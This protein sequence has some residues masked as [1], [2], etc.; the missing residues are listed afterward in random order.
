MNDKHGAVMNKPD[1]LQYGLSL[2]A[3]AGLR[4]RCLA[5]LTLALL[6]GS[7]QLQAV[8]YF[9]SAGGDDSASGTSEST[10]WRTVDRANQVWLNPSDSLSF[11]GGDTFSGS[12]GTRGTGAAGRPIVYKS[13]G[14]GRAIINAGNN[15]GFRINDSYCS[16]SNLNFIGSGRNTG[17]LGVGIDIRGPHV[18][19]DN[20]GVTG[21][22]HQGV[23]VQSSNVR[24]SNTDSSG[25][26]ESGISAWHDTS[27]GTYLTDLYIGHCTTNYNPGDPTSSKWTGSGIVIAG[28]DGAT[29]E[30]CEAGHNCGAMPLATSG[31]YAIWCFTCKHVLI[32][33]CIAHDTMTNGEDGGGIDLDGGTSDSIVQYCLT[34]G[35]QGS[36][37]GMYE[38][39]TTPWARNTIRYCIS[40]NDGVKKHATALNLAMWDNVPVNFTKA[41]VYNNMFYK[42]RD[43]TDGASPGLIAFSDPGSIPSG[44]VFCNNILVS[45]ND[46]LRVVGGG[47]ISYDNIRVLGNCYYKIGGGFDQD[48]QHSLDA[49]SLAFG[50][51]RLNGSMVGL[52]ADPL[53]AAMSTPLTITNPD[54]LTNMSAFKLLAGSPCI[55][56]GIDLQQVLGINPGARD[57]F[58]DTGL[59]HNGIY[60][61][62]AH[63]ADATVSFPTITSISPNNA[64]T[65]GGTTVTITGT[66]LTGS[67]AVTFGGRAATSVTVQSDTALTCVVPS[68]GAGVVDVVVNAAGGTITAANGFTYVR[69]TPTVSWSQPAAIVYGTLLGT[70]QLNA[71][72]GVAGTFTYAPA[73]GT[74]LHAGVGQTLSVTF[75]PA[76]PN[77]YNGTA[78]SISLTVI[79]KVLT[80]TAVDATRA[81][82]AANP[83]FTVSYGGFV[84]SDGAGTLTS[85][86]TASCSAT[87]ASP[88]G[89]YP[90]S[91]SGGA[92]ADYSFSYVAG[93]LTITDLTA[94]TIT[95]I[96]PSSGST[97]GGNTVTITGTHLTGSAHVTFGGRAA[98]ALAVV[99]DTTL[100][101]V[102]PSGDA[103]AVN[104]VVNAAAGTVTFGNGYTHVRD[105]PTISWN[106]PS[107]IVYGTVLGGAE[108]N[109]ISSV[110][111]TFIYAPPAGTLLHV[112]AAQT[113]SVTFTPDN[114]AVYN[115]AVASV[116]LTVIKKALTATAV[117]ATR[118][119]GVANP[120]FTVS[121]SGFVGS[122]GADGLDAQPTASC[123][124]TTT[125]P[126]GTYPIGVSGG[127]DDDYSFT[128]ATGTL[129][130]TDLPAQTITFAALPRKTYGDAPFALSGTSTSGLAVT[131]AS[132]DPTI[133]A[134]SGSQVTIFHAG[135]TTITAKQ[136]GDATHAAAIPVLRILTIARKALTIAADDQTRW[137]S[138]QN[139]VFTVTAHTLV[140]SDTIASSGLAVS[141]SCSA[142]SASPV[143]T[144]PISASGAATTADYTVTYAAGTL[145]VAAPPVTPSI[146][147]VT[148]N[149]GPLTGGTVVTIRG[150]GWSGRMSATFG[151]MAATAMTIVDANTVTCVAPAHVQGAVDVSITCSY[152]TAALPSGF[153]YRD[154][155]TPA[156]G[157]GPGAAVHQQ[158]A[159]CGAGSSFAVLGLMALAFAGA[160]RRR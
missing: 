81:F 13:Y 30:Y 147:S 138:A 96:S 4:A 74:L 54:A 149:S 61:V 48:G 152:G 31:P 127:L 91:V 88:Q 64:S 69:A 52:N 128:Y 63:E 6:L 23:L 82:G 145:T 84:G 53:V 66:H 39:N 59:P 20:V 15:S 58:A 102:V 67:A 51:E 140:G 21:F 16:V 159:G 44:S 132:S 10:P 78:A 75:T 49:W 125:S 144:Y 95:A 18:Q 151:G 160:R 70:A 27:S 90:I 105:T 7:A 12:L 50:T 40:Q 98:T 108:L 93:T 112:G 119:F 5:I 33:C 157:P 65:L 107:A 8:D 131:Y 130:I 117:D 35:N 29:V 139:P 83:A 71:T 92:A 36:G 2:L 22:Q 80:A 19:I 76:D 106:Q 1:W 89:T 142:T 99:N 126:R 129:T 79:K 104:V 158:G 26:G 154:S 150:D 143:G 123:S 135:S 115:G 136:A 57:F 86:P 97:L 62:G 14:N 72:S 137:V 46:F 47:A 111:G 24:I 109:A 87:T 146:R 55:D 28:W 156:P 153:T 141:T 37:Y 101:C 114:P 3:L 32:Q 45:N 38:Y 73:A 122:D 124:A 148:P 41:Y 155:S 94:P 121:Y 100:T 113:V 85:Q 60:D 56:H 68:A 118:A 103:G 120:A 25:N 133:A 17:N 110:G 34:Y 43:N 42:D 134:V 116:T 11:R 9:V 77:V